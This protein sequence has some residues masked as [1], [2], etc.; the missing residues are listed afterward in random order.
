MPHSRTKPK[1]DAHPVKGVKQ[2]SPPS[3]RKVYARDLPLMDL[4]DLRVIVI[5]DNEFAMTLIKRL[6][7]A[8]RV[9]EIFVCSDAGVADKAIHK[10]KPDV[11]IVD[12][13]MPEK[14][15]LQVIH[16]IR[17]GTGVVSKDMPILVVSAHTDREH[18]G[19]ARDAGVNWVLVKPLSFRNLYEGLVRV[20]LDD[21]PFVE[22]G[23]YVGPCRRVRSV[24]YDFPSDRR[25]ANRDGK[26]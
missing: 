1:G 25:L 20:V 15:G 16:D 5:D 12:L 7:T 8:M 22:E 14:S 17:H 9:S 21:R 26:G 24:S 18:V 6:L 2:A 10:A 23:N 3:R 13:D 19:K 11:V 4:R